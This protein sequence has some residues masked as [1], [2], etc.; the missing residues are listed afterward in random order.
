MFNFNEQG[1]FESYDTA[2]EHSQNIDGKPYYNDKQKS[3]KDIIFGIATA[4]IIIVG[5]VILA[6][7]I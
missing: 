2:K 6:Y 4:I 7:I 3:T 1:K 5:T